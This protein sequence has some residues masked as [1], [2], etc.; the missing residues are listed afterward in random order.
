MIDVVA[1]A[2]VLAGAGREAA[3]LP[4]VLV[5]QGGWDEAL[6]V[7]LAIAV[8]LGLR[9]RDRRAEQAGEP[10][11]GDEPPGDGPTD[12]RDRRRGGEDGPER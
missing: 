7:V 4:F 3:E 1:G 9:W 12:Q 5:H 6:L 11:D 8:Y 2:P 10:G